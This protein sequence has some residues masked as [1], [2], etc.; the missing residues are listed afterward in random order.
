MSWKKIRKNLYTA[1]DSCRI[2]CLKSGDR[3]LLIDSGSGKSLSGV[4]DLGIS[5]IDWVLHT[6]PHRDMSLGD[7]DLISE[8]TRFAVPAAAEKL[9]SEA[10]AG[11]KDRNTYY[12]FDYGDK[13]AMPLR[14]IPVHQALKEGD[15][16]DWEGFSLKVMETPGH[17]DYH[18]SFLLELE[19]DRL[20]FSGDLIHSEGR[21][22][23]MDALQGTYEEFIQDEQ[24]IR[25]VPALISSIDR[26]RDLSSDLLLPG[27]GEP[28]SDTDSALQ[29]LK[30]NLVEMMDYL[31]AEAYLNDYLV[32]HPDIDALLC[33]QAS[34][35]I[36][37]NEGKH[38]LIDA[39]FVDS[40]M[41]D[42]PGILLE[43][44]QNRDGFEGLDLIIPTHYHCDHIAATN[45]FVRQW[46]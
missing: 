44:I 41:E 26:I 21:V 20:I 37:N 27:H 17:T 35:L 23:E 24:T 3:G 13:Y 40:V 9:F 4:K 32:T 16:F 10:E 1:E 33:C 36:R 8:G 46:G 25:K 15:T 34:Y 12:A 11:W 6:H 28:I 31:P 5:G 19:G 7:F 29:E 43:W 38:L 42:H 14:D 30:K 45:A 18:M 39:G 22:W 2:Y